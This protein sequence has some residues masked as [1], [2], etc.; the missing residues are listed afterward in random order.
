[1]NSLMDGSRLPHK[2]R[3]VDANPLLNEKPDQG[4]C[5]LKLGTGK[6]RD[7]Y[8]SYELYQLYQLY[9]LC[10]SRLNL[11]I[12]ACLGGLSSQGSIRPKRHP[13]HV[14]SWVS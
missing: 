8:S 9:Q 11:K 12:F 7:V 1:M 10:E 3:S 4:R 2:R 6:I 5:R 13:K 14:T